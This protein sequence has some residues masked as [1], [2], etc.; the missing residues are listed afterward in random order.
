V[1]DSINDPKMAVALARIEGSIVQLTETVALRITHAESEIARVDRRAG[2]AHERLDV[3]HDQLRSELTT[4]IR[5]LKS[6]VDELEQ[7]R[8]QVVGFALGLGALGGVLGGVVSA[9]F[10]KVVGG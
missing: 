1:P 3:A 2:S 10:S 7:W 6:T 8:A 9:L 4:E 5:T